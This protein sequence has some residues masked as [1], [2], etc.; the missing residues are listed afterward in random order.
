MEKSRLFFKVVS[1]DPRLGNAN[2][3]LCS[4]F[5]PWRLAGKVV[6]HLLMDVWK[7]LTAG[8]GCGTVELQCF[9]AMSEME[10]CGSCWDELA[11][12]S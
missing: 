1:A 11:P 3:E 2:G 6:P 12:G 10:L 7:E 9:C 8:A 5:F 4:N